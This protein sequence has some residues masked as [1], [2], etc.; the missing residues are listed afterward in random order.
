MSV[1]C[2]L[3]AHNSKGPQLYRASFL[4]ARP[5]RLIFPFR[6]K[7]KKEEGKKPSQPQKCL[8]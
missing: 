4:S 8:P 5:T 1:S 6:K 2:R 7:K 3:L